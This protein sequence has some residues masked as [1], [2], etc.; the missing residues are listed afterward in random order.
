MASLSFAHFPYL[1]SWQ[2]TRTNHQPVS[3]AQLQDIRFRNRLKKIAAISGDEGAT[4]NGRVVKKKKATKTTK[5]ATTRTKKKPVVA[6]GASEEEDS[7]TDDVLHVE[8]VRSVPGESY[9]KGTRI[10][11]KKALSASVETEEEKPDKKVRRGR[12][13]NKKDEIVKDQSNES[14]VSDVDG[15]GSFVSNNVEDSSDD[16]DLDF[17]DKDEGEDISHTYGWPPLVCCF[18]AAQHAFV[19]SGRRANRLLNYEIHDRMRDA[20]WEPENFVRAPGGCAG[21]V[22]VALASLGGKVAFM[23]KLGDDDFGQA[24][25]YY[26]NVSK[27]QTRSVRMD[28][29]RATAVSHMRIAKRGRLRM[30]CTR[31]CAEDCLTKSEINIDVLK[32]AKMFYFNTHPLLE[33]N[34]RSSTLR[35]IKISQKLGG[36]IFYDV[37]LPMPLWQSSEETKEFIRD[38]WNLANVIEVTKQELEFLC[39]IEPTEEFDTRNNDVSKFVHYEKEVVD[40]L[41]HENLQVLFVTN[42]TSEIHYY[43]R[44]HNGSVLGMEDPP[45]TPFTSDMSASGDGIVAGM[46]RMLSVQPHLITDE[47][48]LKRLIRYA[49]DC[50]VIDQWM[51]ARTRGFPPHEEMEDEEIEPDASGMRS[52]TEQEHRTVLSPSQ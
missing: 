4:E 7:D 50:G 9:R 46:L 10:T 26:M 28:G 16:G 20:Y 5:R 21:G 27:V 15:E 36:V 24:L 31:P 33:R 8:A 17:L 1:P 47:G 44:E 22:A 30:T 45:L 52:I 41:W 42:G 32:E 25:L 3:Y 48:Y 11:R 39:G 23:G 38:A 14:D 37:N 2:S 43:T 18:G 35:A 12:K 34:M 40:Q 6:D 13:A 29:K 19:P 49:I 51:L